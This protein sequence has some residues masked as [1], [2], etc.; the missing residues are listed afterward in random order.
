MKWLNIG[1]KLLPFILSCVQAV[2]GFIKGSQRGEE[3]ENAAV[4]MVHAILQTIEAGVDRDLLN[5]DDVNR[6]VR[7][8]MQAFV[9]LENVIASKQPYAPSE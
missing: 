2:E 4:G 7:K 3:K 1:I 6:A 8:C 9:A 5:D